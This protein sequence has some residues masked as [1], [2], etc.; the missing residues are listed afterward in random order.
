M[1][2][3][4]KQL[5]K[6][7]WLATIIAL[8]VAAA[9]VA[10][11]YFF[12]PESPYHK[13]NVFVFRFEQ[14][15]TLEKGDAVCINGLPK[16][17]VSKTERTEDEV[18]VTTEILVEVK[19]PVDSRF[20]VVNA[21]FMGERQVGITLGDSERY[22]SPG[23]TIFGNFDEGMSGLSSKMNSVF[24]GIDYCLTT[25]VASVDT[26]FGGK[27]GERLDRVV[28]KGK[29]ILG[30]TE[31]LVS[32]AVPELKKS[33]GDVTDALQ[34]TKAELEKV[35][36]STGEKLESV[37]ALLK[38]TEAVLDE[39]LALKAE[40]ET[41]I[42]KAEDLINS[43]PLRTSCKNLVASVTGLRAEIMKEKLKFNVD[44]F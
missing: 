11:L 39:A 35:A 44:I 25:F 4:L 3:K 1:N 36:N 34:K 10:L 37:E 5:I 22:V 21:G 19:I 42:G 15:G 26:L 20:Q 31:G 29:T 28:S 41:S 43:E 2:R 18:F 33:I 12:H 8:V 17:R 13:R 14:V 24:S 27:N 40:V 30:E 6:R 32:E 7:N 38:R 16:G 23:D 9:C